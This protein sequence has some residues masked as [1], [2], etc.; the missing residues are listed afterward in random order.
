MTG[1][2]SLAPYIEQTL[3]KAT[4]T[5]E[6]IVEL[7]R[8][9]IEHGFHGVCVSPI[10]VGLAAR[11]TLGSAVRVVTVAGFPLGAEMF[12]VTARA[13][14]QA[15]RAGAHEIDM[16]APIGLVLGGDIESVRV[17]VDAVRRAV[18]ESV[19][20]VILETGYLDDARTEL[21][22]RA[23][24][25]AGADFLKTSTGFGPRG[26]TVA[27]VTLLTRVAAGVVRVKASGGIKTADAAR[28]LVAAG[29]ERLGTSSGVE[30]VT[31]RAGAADY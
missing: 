28:A 2:H 14:E 13:A 1:K 6:Q 24:V 26:A 23:A 9:A 16:V 21:A 5:P 15:V 3:L 11:M 7:C 22:A 25:E 17:A 12:Q 31:E 27:D 8:G 4:A 18:P 10:H 20:K 19:L 29:A 30:I